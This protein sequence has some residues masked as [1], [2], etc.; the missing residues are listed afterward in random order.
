M[1]KIALLS[2]ALMATLAAAVSA[3]VPAEADFTICTYKCICSVPHRC[4]GTVCTPDPSSPLQC[5]QVYDC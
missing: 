1:R 3:P 5:P 4:C 2:L